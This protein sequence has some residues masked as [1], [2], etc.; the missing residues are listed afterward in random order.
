MIGLTV[1]TTGAK[2]VVVLPMAS[3]ATNWMPWRTLRTRFQRVSERDRSGEMVGV[4]VLV[5]D[6]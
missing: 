5:L 6:S 1:W 4:T 2:A 3:I